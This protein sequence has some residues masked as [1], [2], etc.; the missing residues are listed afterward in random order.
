MSAN[1]TKQFFDQ[2]HLN[3]RLQVIPRSPSP[4]ITERLYRL[5]NDI[6]SFLMMC[7]DEEFCNFW[8]AITHLRQYIQIQTRR[9][10]MPKFLNSRR[11]NRSFIRILAVLADLNYPQMHL[12]S[13][14][15]SYLDRQLEASGHLSSAV[16]Q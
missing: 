13:S 10:T 1:N 3:P 6:E 5:I 12:S 15:D 9:P 11:K 4:S 14:L 16:A 2:R 8:Q 7:N